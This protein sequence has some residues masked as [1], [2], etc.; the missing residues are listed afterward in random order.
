[1]AKLF[2][3]KKFLLKKV[4]FL[5]FFVTTTCTYSQNNNYVE[6]NSD[7]LITFAKK[8]I[9]VPYLWAGETAKGFDCSGFVY[10]VYKHFG[11]ETT[12]NSYDFPK[13]GNFISIDSCKV[14]DVILF[15]REKSKNN[16]IGHVGIVISNFGEP[17]KFIQSSSSKK[18]NGVIITDYNNSHYKN[19]FIGVIRLIKDKC[20]QKSNT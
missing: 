7:S 1:M 20:L 4:F 17:L 5:L 8:Y 11:I 10:F 3:I 13:Y 2:N 18:H 14:G 15:T 9:G 12:H 19:R 6:V 16:K